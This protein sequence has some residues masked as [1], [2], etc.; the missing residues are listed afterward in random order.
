MRFR[1][2]T[3]LERTTAGLG[4]GARARGQSTQVR[5][6]PVIVVRMVSR[7]CGEVVEINIAEVAVRRETGIDEADADT[8]SVDA[9]HR[10]AKRRGELRAGQLRV[11]LSARD[12][13]VDHRRVER[14]TFD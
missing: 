8:A 6:V 5:A 1:R 3:L 9:L 10:E 12:R 7:R 2:E 14:K 4:Q 13:R 11:A